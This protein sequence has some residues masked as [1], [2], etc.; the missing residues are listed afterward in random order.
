M[1]SCSYVSLM[2][3]MMSMHVFGEMPLFHGIIYQTFRITR[4]YLDTSLSLFVPRR[5][6]VLDDAHFFNKL[7]GKLEVDAFVDAVQNLVPR[8]AA[9]SQA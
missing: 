3:R 9:A 4:L 6:Q 8:D 5:L 2:A 1:R 7:N